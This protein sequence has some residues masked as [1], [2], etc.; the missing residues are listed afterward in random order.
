LELARAL[1]EID[2][3]EGAGQYKSLVDEGLL[4][5]EVITDLQDWVQAQPNERVVRVLLAEALTKAGRLPEAVEQYR[6][7]V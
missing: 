5:G 4:L 2:I 3:H 6:L 1:R 7:L